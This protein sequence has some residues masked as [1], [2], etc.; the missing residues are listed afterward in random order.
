MML[1]R[2]FILGLDIDFVA[3]SSHPLTKNETKYDFAAMVPLQ[4]E[5]SLTGLKNIKKLIV[6]G[7][8]MSK[9]LENSL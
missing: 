9:S 2:S 5:N 3:P 6:G 4:V 1:V 8:K 7:A